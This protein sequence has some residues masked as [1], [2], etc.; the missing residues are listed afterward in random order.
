VPLAIPLALSLPPVGRWT[1]SS[2]LS[3]VQA[4][5]IP[6]PRI[7]RRSSS[8]PAAPAG[9]PIQPRL[10]EEVFGRLVSAVGIKVEPG[11][12][13][14][15][16]HELRSLGL[17]LHRVCHGREFARHLGSH[18]S[19]QVADLYQDP[20]GSGWLVIPLPTRP[21][22]GRQGATSTAAALFGP[23]EHSS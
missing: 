6:S 12:T 17:R 8:R 21:S 4:D 13:R 5:G 2:I 11:R 9:S 3:A 1:I 19:D 18:E 15:T 7:I 22:P 20:R 23:R 16:P 10:A 14:P